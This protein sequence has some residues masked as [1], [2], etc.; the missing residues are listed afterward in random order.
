VKRKSLSD[1]QLRI[2]S[3]LSVAG[4]MLSVLCAA[5]CLLG[6]LFQR[7]ARYW[8]GLCAL[9]VLLLPVPITIVIHWRREGER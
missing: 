1:G 5:A 2:L 7:D 9:P 3:D 6:A 8:L 4:V